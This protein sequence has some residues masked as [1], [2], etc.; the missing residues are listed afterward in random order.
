[1]AANAVARQRIGFIGLG[2]MGRR[3]AARL[4]DAGYTVTVYD[5]TSEKTRPLAEK[6]AA[7]AATPRQLAAH[8]DVVILSVTDDTAVREVMLGADGVLAG[9]R[10]DSMVI[11][12]S[13][14]LPET[15]RRVCEAARAKGVSM[16]DAPVSGSTPQAEQGVLTIFVGGEHKT[17]ERC[18]PILEVLGK[19]VWYMGPSGAG[20]TMKLVVNTLLGVEMQAI[21]EAIALGEKA[22]LEKGRLLDVLEQTTLIAPAHKAKFAN[23]RREEYPVTFA[24]RLMHKDFGLIQQQATSLAVPMPATAAA[25]QACV[26]EQARSTEEDYSAVIRLMEEWA[27]VT[28]RPV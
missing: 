21:A 1:M 12:L 8:C 18:K 24:L 4:I 11:D 13:S 15:S 17:F 20:T 3:M 9:V 5:R 2:H 7:V 10:E 22:G 23:A 6:G 25:Q 19:T 26:A 14:V 16:I 27:G 28:P